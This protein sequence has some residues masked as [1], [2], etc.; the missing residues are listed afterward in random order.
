MK[1]KVGIAVLLT[2][3]SLYSQESIN[4]TDHALIQFAQNRTTAFKKLNTTPIY[5]PS[6]YSTLCGPPPM[7]LLVNEPH[8]LHE[9]SYIN[10]FISTNAPLT[11]KTRNLKYPVPTGTIVLKQKLTAPDKG[12]TI[13]FTGML[14]REKGYNPSSGDWEFFTI[15]GK[16]QTITARGKIDSCIDC[17]KAYKN[18]DYLSEY[19]QT[20]PAK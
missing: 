13:L 8:N 12:E 6:K 15:D 17:H 16:E 7:P 3:S 2:C 19:W 20:N 11:G 18:T 10:I 5:F 9:S 4:L 1:T 14:K